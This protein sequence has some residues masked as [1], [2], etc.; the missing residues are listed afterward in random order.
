MQ[1]RSHSY[2]LPYFLEDVEVP[3]LNPTIG[4]VSRADASPE[5]FADIVIRKIRTVI[6]RQSR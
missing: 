3:G 6:P 5:E 1:Q 4:Y 2:L